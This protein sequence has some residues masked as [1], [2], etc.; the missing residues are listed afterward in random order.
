LPGHIQGSAHPATGDAAFSIFFVNNKE[1][2]VF[3]N[4]KS[5]LLRKEMVGYRKSDG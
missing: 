1:E 2:N 5:E 4:V 3:L